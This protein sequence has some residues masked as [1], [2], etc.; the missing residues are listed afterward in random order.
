[1]VKSSTITMNAAVVP[2]KI[3]QFWDV[4]DPPYKLKNCCFFS[5]LKNFCLKHEQLLLS[6][7]P[8]KPPDNRFV[9]VTVYLS[10]E[11]TELSFEFSLEFFLQQQQYK[12][13]DRI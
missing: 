5:L 7:L 12:T 9:S 13:T 11:S 1:M 10:A 8:A 4:S 3:S 6:S 2:A